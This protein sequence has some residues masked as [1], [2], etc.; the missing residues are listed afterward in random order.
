MLLFSFEDR[1]FVPLGMQDGRITKSRVR[2]SSMYNRY[3]GPYNA[4]LQARN[5]GSTRGAWVAR[6]RNTQQ[7]IQIDLEKDTTLKGLATQGRYDAN[8]YVKSYV[9]TY[10]RNGRRFYPY[11]EGRRTR[12]IHFEQN[13]C[14][15]FAFRVHSNQDKLENASF[16]LGLGL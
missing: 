2:A 5:Y 15:W 7:W 8:Q 16:S 10:S 6:I 14:N 1:C 9:I 4:R 11:K 13:S 12:V 3:Y